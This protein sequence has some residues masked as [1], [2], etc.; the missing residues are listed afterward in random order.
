MLL[1]SG[2]WIQPAEEVL[3]GFTWLLQ[4]QGF[5]RLGNM[6]WLKS[7]HGEVVK[8]SG[9]RYQVQILPLPPGSREA[10]DKRLCALAS[11]SIQ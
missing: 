10:L 2:C 4:T 11:S 1:G 6:A 7:L 9:A 8:G 3:G 5:H